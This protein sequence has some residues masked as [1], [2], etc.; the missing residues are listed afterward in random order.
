MLILQ[1][2]RVIEEAQ[3]WEGDLIFTVG[4]QQLRVPDFVEHVSLKHLLRVEIL[5]MKVKSKNNTEFKYTP[6][7]DIID[8]DNTSVI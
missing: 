7:C 6:I 1:V 5:K 3:E 4:N 8:I 2:S